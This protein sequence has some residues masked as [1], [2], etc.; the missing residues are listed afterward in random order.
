MNVNT[1]ALWR[2][3]IIAP[4][5][6]ANGPRGAR[7]RL[8]R[9]ICQRTHEHPLRGSIRLG[10]RTVQEWLYDY[11]KDGLDGLLPVP[12]KDR[13]KSR[14]IDPEM[15]AK[16]EALA[17]GHPELDGPGLL[18]NCGPRA[19]RLRPARRSTASCGHAVWITGAPRRASIIAPTSSTSPVIAGKVT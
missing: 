12:R 5:L 7:I 15:A 19:S 10:T 11:L 8:I 1:I 9:E 17:R 16:I 4:L 2:Y 14:R 13:G 18:P 6:S 3:Q